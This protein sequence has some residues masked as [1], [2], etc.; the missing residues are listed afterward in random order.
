MIIISIKMAGAGAIATSTYLIF[1][2][3]EAA[4]FPI[5]WLISPPHKVRRNDGTAI[6]QGEK[7]PIVDELWLVWAALK[8][9]RVSAGDF[10]KD[11]R[12]QGY[13]G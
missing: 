12:I 4:A 6:R 13:D 3:I 11:C 9:K 7:L 5:S 10:R 1:V 2:G 8:H